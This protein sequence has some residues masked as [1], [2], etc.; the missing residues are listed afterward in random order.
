M[1]ASGIACIPD[2]TI[3]IAKGKEV[4]TV[5]I[6]IAEGV[7]CQ[8]WKIDSEL[9]EE[10]SIKPSPAVEG[11]YRRAE[12]TTGTKSGTIDSVTSDRGLSTTN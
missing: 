5:P 11:V 12:I 4:Q 6:T 2:E 3:K 7:E 9:R 10:G 1:R 8:R